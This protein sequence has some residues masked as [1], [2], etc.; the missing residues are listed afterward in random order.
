MNMPM[1]PRLRAAKACAIS[2][3]ILLAPSLGAAAQPAATSSDDMAGM[4]MSGMDM[5]NMPGM[6]MPAPKKTHQKHVNKPAAT[7]APTT[8]ATP[9]ADSSMP[10]M[11]MP[12]DHSAPPASGQAAA[13]ASSGTMPAMDMGS[14]PGMGAP[15][16]STPAMVGTAMPADQG[17]RKD[18][19]HDQAPAMGD[20]GGMNMAPMRGGKAPADARSPDYSEGVRYGSMQGMDMNDNA[21]M[22]TLLVDQLEAFHGRDGNGQRW[23][24][25]GWYGGDINKLWVRTEGERSADKI[26][27]GDVEAFWNRNVSVFWST[28]LGV[29]H[30]VNDGPHRNWAAFGV[31]GV[32]PYWFDVEATAYAGPAG[33]TAARLRSSY[34]LLLTQRLVLQ[35]EA[36]ANAFGLSDPVNGIGSGMSDGRLGLRLRY[37]IRREFAPYVGVEWTRRFGETAEIARDTQQPVADTQWVAG[38]RFWF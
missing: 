22:G 12:M 9:A 25:Q 34:D 17:A 37:E 29:R 35:P 38:L 19:V 10:G 1:K 36:E 16:S 8:P 28:Q 30:D 33:R 13:P 24:A 27:E 23:E 7:P 26:S 4:D 5:S 15:A 11:S 31:Q 3:S 32:A 21:S 14:M 20:M 18:T 2:L 6:D